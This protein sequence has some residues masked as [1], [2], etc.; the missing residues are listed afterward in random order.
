MNSFYQSDFNPNNILQYMS[1]AEAKRGKDQNLFHKVSSMNDMRVPVVFLGI[2]M[3]IS[4]IFIL[5]DELNWLDFIFYI[6]IPI[7]LCILFFFYTANKTYTIK[8]SNKAVSKKF[9]L[10]RAISINYNDIDMAC[11]IIPNINNVYLVSNQLNNSAITIMGMSLLIKSQNNEIVLPVGKIK[12]F[13]E[14]YKIFRLNF[15][16]ENSQQALR[17][18]A[19][20]YIQIGVDLENKIVVTPDPFEL[21]NGYPFDI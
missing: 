16:N 6:T 13:A 20:A 10:K 19:L 5:L 2:D 9:L 3:I 18:I 8:V 15:P 17:D 11:A 14:Y 4:L 21:S 12:G 7:A 1:L